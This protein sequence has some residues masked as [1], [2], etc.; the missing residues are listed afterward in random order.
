MV[1]AEAKKLSIKMD[2]KRMVEEIIGC[3]WSLSVLDMI[4]GG[5]HRPGAMERE[6]GGLT[7]K[8]LNER[9]RKLVK[10]GIVV[11][12]EFPEIPPRVEYYLTPYGEKFVRV[13]ELIATLD[14]DVA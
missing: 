11:K 5:I 10:F 3:K 8:V 2:A 9:L 13:L 4:N 6:I 12:R 14:S 7:A 1:Q